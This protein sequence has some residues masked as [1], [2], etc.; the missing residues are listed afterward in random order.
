M[1]E[2]QNPVVKPGQISQKPEQDGMRETKVFGDGKCINKL[3]VYVVGVS[4]GQIDNVKHGVVENGGRLRP[5]ALGVVEIDNR[6]NEV[7]SRRIG[8]RL[9]KKMNAIVLGEDV[10]DQ[11]RSGRHS[12][13]QTPMAMAA[14]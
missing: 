13:R 4:R 14:V 12:G 7:E 10:V 9:G 2:L 1:V 6:V 8:C 5:A 11:L 3:H